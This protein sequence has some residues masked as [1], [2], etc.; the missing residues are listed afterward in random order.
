MRRPRF[1]IRTLLAIAFVVSLACWFAL[2][3]RPSVAIVGHEIETGS[4]RWDGAPIHVVK[5]RN[6][7]LLP[8]YYI[9]HSG[10]VS[11][12]SIVKSGKDGDNDWFSN[13]AS[14]IHWTLLHRGQVAAIEFAVHGDYNSVTVATEVSDWRGRFARVSAGPFLFD[15]TDNHRLQRS[16]GG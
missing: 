12:L 6:D 16:G 15:G 11:N 9:G 8:I 1:S 3:F 4:S 2:P 14:P 10:L 13:S 5:I 7:G